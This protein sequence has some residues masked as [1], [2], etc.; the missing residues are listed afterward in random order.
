LV[1]DTGRTTPALLALEDGT[2][3]RGWGFGADVDSAGEIVFNTAI[4][5]YQEVITDPSYRGQI[6]T[7]TAPEIGNVGVNPIDFESSRPWCAGFVVRELSPVVSNW[8]ADSDLA[9]LLIDSN[10][11]GISG[12]DTRAITR[13]LRQSGAQ[14]AV[15]TRNVADSGA[16]VAAAR[17]HPSLEGRDLV[18]EVTAAAPYEWDETIWRGLRSGV[19]GQDLGQDDGQD[20][21]SDADLGHDLRRIEGQ[22][23]SFQYGDGHADQFAARPPERHHV[24]AYDYGIKRGILRRLRSCGCR[25]TVVPAATSAKEVLSRK[26]DGI[27]LSNGPGDP[28]ALPYAVEAARELVKTG[29][30]VFGICLGHQI[31]GQALGGKTYKLKFGHHGANHPVMDL[32]TRKVEITSQNHGFAV[33]VESMAGCAV[34][35]HVSLNDRTVEGMRHDHLPVFSVQYHPE[36]SPG[37]NDSCYLFDRFTRLMDERRRT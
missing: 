21:P 9:R 5:G 2:V 20:R 22:A 28:A 36:A 37:P 7:M 4:T 3:Y 15:I 13:R 19:Q 26:P 18:R 31:L 8:R 32:G 17:R 11:A 16:A 34:L 27:F 14:R 10:V 35:T 12:I 30:P 1:E 23:R 29:I 6:V 24:I 33:D 25:V